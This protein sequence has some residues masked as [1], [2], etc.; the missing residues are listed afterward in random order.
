MISIGSSDRSRFADVV[1]L[2]VIMFT[3]IHAGDFDFFCASILFPYAYTSF[4]LCSPARN[5]E[6]QLSARSSPQCDPTYAYLTRLIYN[7]LLGNPC[8]Q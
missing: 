3:A 7:E 4:P 6:G 5:H 1:V 8:H 2:T